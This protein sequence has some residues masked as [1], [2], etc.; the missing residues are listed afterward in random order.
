MSSEVAVA[1]KR[2]RPAKGGGGPPPTKAK[3]GPTVCVAEA[4]AKAEAEAK[5]KAKAKAKAHHDVP[6]GFVA[7]QAKALPQ[8]A[9]IPPA[10]P[11]F[12][13]PSLGVT[14]TLTP[15]LNTGVEVTPAAKSSGWQ[16][17]WS[18]YKT[19]TGPGWDGRGCT[20]QVKKYDL[21][22]PCWEAMGGYGGSSGSGGPP[23]LPP[24]ATIYM[25]GLMEDI[26]RCV[27]RSLHMPKR[28]DSLKR[29]LDD[30]MK[31]DGED[32]AK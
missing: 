14:S 11:A 13:P 19:C 4:K 16:Q 1:M 8:R 7:P 24:E 9:T 28:P 15:E 32:G 27:F 6:F 20:T 22:R 21:C 26:W 31:R 17:S 3:G 18:G 5:A 23:P 29:W 2:S 12:A 10:G 30:H 25:I